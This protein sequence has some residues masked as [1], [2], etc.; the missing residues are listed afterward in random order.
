MTTKQMVPSCMRSLYTKCGSEGGKWH[1]NK[2]WLLIS[3]NYQCLFIVTYV[4]RD[5][6]I[7]TKGK[8]LGRWLRITS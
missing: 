1:P 3:S 4:S 5:L 2:D 8:K 6:K 7:L